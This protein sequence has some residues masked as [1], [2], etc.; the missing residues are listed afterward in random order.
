MSKPAPQND[1]GT[2]SAAAGIWAPEFNLTQ[3]ARSNHQI[4]ADFAGIR[5]CLPFTRRTGV[6]VAVIRWRS[7]HEMLS[8]FK[9][10][11]S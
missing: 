8:E 6:P 4:E 1:P 11:G 7:I 9:E 5:L 2:A 10:L 3:H